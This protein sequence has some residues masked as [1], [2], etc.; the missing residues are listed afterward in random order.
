[1]KLIVNKYVNNKEQINIGMTNRIWWRNY[2][3]AVTT[4]SIF[5][6]SFHHLS[7]LLTKTNVFDK[8]MGLCHSLDG[9]KM[10]LFGKRRGHCISLM[11]NKRLVDTIRSGL[12]IIFFLEINFNIIIIYDDVECSGR[13]H[14]CGK[15]QKMPNWKLGF[16]DSRRLCENNRV[17]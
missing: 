6:I 8:F 14:F 10:E 17:R 11:Y 15:C 2:E 4:S 3:T 16:Q 12:L 7:T 5:S 13:K 9:S 1:M